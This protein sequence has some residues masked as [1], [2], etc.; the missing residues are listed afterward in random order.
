MAADNKWLHDMIDGMTQH[1]REL[2]QENKQLKAALI[3]IE[4]TARYE[5]RQVGFYEDNN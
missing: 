5:L 1:I 4:S 3:S 2:E